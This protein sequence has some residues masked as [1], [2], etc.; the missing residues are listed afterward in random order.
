MLDAADDFKAA[1]GHWREATGEWL[2]VTEPDTS[3]HLET[4]VMTWIRLSTGQLCI[5]VT[6]GNERD[7]TELN[8]SPPDPSPSLAINLMSGTGP[9]LDQNLMST[10]TL[11]GIHL[12]LCFTGDWRYFRIS[13]P[14]TVLLGSLSWAKPCDSCFHPFVENALS[15]HLKFSD[16]NATGWTASGSSFD[17]VLS[18]T[19]W[20]R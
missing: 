3:W 14:R 15:N 18:P 12:I 13:E 17:S 2:V 10:M 11:N 6:D 8:W 5:E 20:T 16:V 7:H 9:T 1:L 19:G 4:G